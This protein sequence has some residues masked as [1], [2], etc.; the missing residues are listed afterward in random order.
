MYK[1]VSRGACKHHALQILTTGI[2]RSMLTQS[3]QIFQHI[4]SSILLYRSVL[5]W[6]K[7]CAGWQAEEHI[8]GLGL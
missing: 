4:N 3:L 7:V 1:Q 5:A 6:A 2:L 8:S